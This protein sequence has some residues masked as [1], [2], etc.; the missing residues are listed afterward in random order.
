MPNRLIARV[1]CDAAGD[2]R[3][4]DIAQTGTQELIPEHSPSPTSTPTLSGEAV[5]DALKMIL[6]GTPLSEVLTSVTRLIETQ[7]PG[8]LCSIF[9]LDAAGVHLRYAAAPSLPESYRAATDGLAT[10]PNAGS[11]G[12]AVYRREAVFV[13]Q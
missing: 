12:A 7:R 4:Q 9:L 6:I 10:G 8:M 3:M 5:L 11:C 2:R 13:Q 1:L